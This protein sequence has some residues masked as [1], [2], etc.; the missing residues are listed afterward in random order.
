VIISSACPKSRFIAD[1]IW[2]LELES[3]DPP[4]NML[5]GMDQISIGQR[6]SHSIRDNFSVPISQFTW[7]YRQSFSGTSRRFHQ[8]RSSLR[9]LD[10][11]C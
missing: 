11:V 7:Q 4:E 5:F 6:R 8:G 1:Q 9:I 2:V 10:I 3:L